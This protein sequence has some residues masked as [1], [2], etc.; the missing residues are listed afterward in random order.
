MLVQIL[1]P[2]YLYAT[3]QISICCTHFDYVE[4]SIPNATIFKK[5]VVRA[6]KN[7]LNKSVTQFRIKIDK[8]MG[9]TLFN[10]ATALNE[11]L[12]YKLRFIQWRR[13][14]SRKGNILGNMFVHTIVFRIVHTLSY[15]SIFNSE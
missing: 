11:N 4:C 12:Y 10:W 7:A 3:A 15:L 9:Y 5:I 6:E 2:L 1:S 8:N 13:S 14:V